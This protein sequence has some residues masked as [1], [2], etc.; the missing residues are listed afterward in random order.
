L[1][2]WRDDALRRVIIDRTF[3]DAAGV[4]WIV[5]FKLSQHEGGSPEAFLDSERERYREQLEDY[6]RVMRGIDA[7]PIRLALYFPLLCGWR[8]WDAP[9]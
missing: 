9:V 7:R 6:A 2:G 8:E 1:T 4:R 3:V 5:D